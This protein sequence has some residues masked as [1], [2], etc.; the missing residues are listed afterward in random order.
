ML[1]AALSILAQAAASPPPPDIAFQAHIAARSLTIEK[2]GDVNL[3]LTG[4]GDNL[5]KVEAP[6]ANGRKRIDNPRIN[7]DVEVRID[8]PDAADPR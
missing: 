4:N 1:V 3:T 2:Q 6:K 8:G 7:V 5:V